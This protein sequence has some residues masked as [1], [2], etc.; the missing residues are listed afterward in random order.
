MAQTTIQRKLEMARQELLDLG[1]RN[2]L[3]NYRTLK[4]RGLE[5]FREK[6]EHVYKILVADKK[7]MSFL[8]AAN[9]PDSAQLTLPE[10][11]VPYAEDSE[12]QQAAYVDLNSKR[13][14]P[15][16]SWSTDC[17]VRITWPERMLK[18]KG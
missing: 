9:R 5:I 7:K 10:E 1:L 3:L 17:L 18:N 16:S 4:A 2:P 8:E 11:E 13:T 12:V 15:R 6:P 14:I